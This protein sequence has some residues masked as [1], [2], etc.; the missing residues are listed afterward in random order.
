MGQK[1]GGGCLVCREEDTEGRDTEGGE[2]LWKCDLSAV[3]GT[4]W[5][6]DTVSSIVLADSMPVS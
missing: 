5:F 6:K 3:C 2:G 4:D 1:W